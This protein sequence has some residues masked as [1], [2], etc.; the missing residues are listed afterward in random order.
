MAR[1]SSG[2]QT[3]AGEGTRLWPFLLSGLD[4]YNT[5]G[6]VYV[7]G[8]P[9]AEGQIFQ[10]KDAK[11]RKIHMVVKDKGNRVPLSRRFSD[12]SR[13]GVH[14]EYSDPAED[15]RNRGSGDAVLSY[16]VNRK[17]KGDVLCLANDNLY[18]HNFSRLMEEH[19]KSGA[20][21]SI[22]TTR[23]PARFAIDNYGVVA[24]DAQNRALK[25][26]EKPKTDDEIRGAFGYLPSEDLSGK[27]IPINTGGY[28]F[29]AG[30]LA[31]IAKESWVAKARA[32]GEFDMARVLLKKLVDSRRYVHTIPIDEWGDLGTLSAF[33]TTFPDALSGKFNSLC[34]IL[35][36]AE[37]SP[38]SKKYH[39][40]KKHNAWIHIETLRKRVSGVTLDKLLYSGRVNLGKNIFVGRGVTIEPDTS[41]NDS[42]LEKYSSVKGGAEL[43]RVYL[44]ARS[45]AGAARLRDCIISDDVT[46]EPSKRDTYINGGTVIA[47]GVSVPSNTRLIATVVYPGY[48]FSGPGEV[49]QESHLFPT[50]AM[51]VGRSYRAFG[52][53]NQ[54]DFDKA[55][56]LGLK[57]VVEYRKHLVK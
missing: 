10:F 13:Y 51:V 6:L 50:D 11:I 43:N 37:Y 42:D 18:D 15:S 5:K 22:L 34:R 44:G 2:M 40:D 39:H 36:T 35:E 29:D 1:K 30:G 16:I 20:L 7:M 12:G 14:I 27:R 4:D 33:L 28:I 54:A 49:H 55:R 57:N 3:A 26:E 45:V 32:H 41:I 31:K 53:T 19:R 47:P 56:A 8:V 23:V 17:L 21:V 25:V 38:K 24:V 48:E 9:I 46:I 52:F